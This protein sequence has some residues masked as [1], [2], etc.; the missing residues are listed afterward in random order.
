MRGTDPIDRGLLSVYAFR[1]GTG[2]V[3]PTFLRLYANHPNIVDFSDADTFKPQFSMVLPED[4]G[5]V[6]VPLR[7]AAFSS[8]NSLSVHFVCTPCFALRGVRC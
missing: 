4:A 2:D 6:E 5:I 7:A 1:V 3:R 8:V